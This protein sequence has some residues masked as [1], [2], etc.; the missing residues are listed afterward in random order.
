MKK[1]PYLVL[2]LLLAAGATLG[3]EATLK[4]GDPAPRLSIAEWVKGDPVPAFEEGKV[5]LVEFW[6]TWCG[7]CIA[8]MPHLSKLQKKHGDKLVIIGVTSEDPNNALDAVKSFVAERGDGIGYRIA[9]DQGRTTN[10][11]Y[12]DAARQRGI[13]CSFL[14]DG[15]GKI[16][17]ISHPMQIDLPLKMCVEGTWDPVTGPARMKEL[18][19]ELEA[20][21]KAGAPAAI[22]DALDALAKKNPELIEGFAGQRFQLMLHAERFD[23][24]S[25]LG[26][27][28]VEEAIAYSDPQ[29]LNEV[30]WTIVD[31]QQPWKTRDVKLARRAAEKAVELTKS[32]DG[33]ILD[34][35]AR[36]IFIEGDVPK[37]IELQ[38]KAIAAAEASGDEKMAAPLEN[39]LDEYEAAT[40]KAG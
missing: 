22:L 20:A 35:L 7:P 38:K 39:A 32:T 8:S 31:P 29:G 34:T 2:A 19:G 14:I 23:Q 24:A 15:K 17:V 16:A 11:A 33:A 27:K 1:L 18:Y 12:M 9:W 21:F 40:E 36:V 3:Q 5:Y 30:A 26:T 37:A 4:A 10:A 6:A 28:L 13:P 25:T